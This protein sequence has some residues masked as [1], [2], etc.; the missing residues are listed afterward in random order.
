MVIATDTTAGTAP[1]AG[2]RAAADTAMRP[3]PPLL[4]R[5][6]EVVEMLGLS[7]SV[8]FE[9]LRSG[10]LRSVTQ[11]RARLIPASA[12]LD[13]V[14]LLEREAAQGTGD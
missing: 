2:A 9:L 3:G 6:P 8:V 14:S 1:P 4:Y 5:V 13:Y 12:V 11:G 7:R 10:R